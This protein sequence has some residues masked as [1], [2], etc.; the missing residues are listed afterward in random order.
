MEIKSSMEIKAVVILDHRAS[1]EDRKFLFEVLDWLFEAIKTNPGDE[2]LKGNKLLWS[3]VEV[4]RAKKTRMNEMEFGI[5][6]DPLAYY[7][8]SAWKANLPKIELVAL[9][10]LETSI[11]SFNNKNAP[12][13]PGFTKEIQTNGVARLELAKSLAKEILSA[14][15]ALSNLAMNP[16]KRSSEMLSRTTTGFESAAKNLE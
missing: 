15:V 4:F 11:L 10:D 13:P 6:A 12:Y 8:D 1:S 3:I 14:Y 9:F 2:N 16:I 5:I 7:A